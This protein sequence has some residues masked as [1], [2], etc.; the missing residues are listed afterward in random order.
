MW[1]LS[2]RFPHQNPVYASHL[3]HMRYMPHPSHSSQFCHKSDTS[4]CLN[5]QGM[6]LL[7]TANKHSSGKCNSICRLNYW[8]S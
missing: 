8:W 3:P 5:Y 4:D 1:S 6:S 2:F 7:S